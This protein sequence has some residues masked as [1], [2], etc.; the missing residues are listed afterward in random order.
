MINSWKQD[1]RKEDASNS[2]N[3]IEASC[4]I[5]IVFPPYTLSLSN[6]FV[7]RCA[8]ACVSLPLLFTGRRVSLIS[9]CGL[10]RDSVL[11]NTL[12]H[13]WMIRRKGKAESKHKFRRRRVVG[14][15][16]H[17]FE[18]V[19]F[20]SATNIYLLW[21]PHCM[22]ASSLPHSIESAWF[23]NN[24]R[25]EKRAEGREGIITLRGEFT[26]RLLR[27]VVCKPTRLGLMRWIE[28]WRRVLLYIFL[29]LAGK[30]LA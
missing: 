27:F 10:E 7:S 16:R 8:C 18:W 30:E 29:W 5:G 2:N 6:T 11:T 24:C 17:I 12:S 21:K 9:T 25:R 26:V 23:Y 14:A 1:T 20:T 13:R 28:K 3:R 22:L 15:W 4:V 19:Y